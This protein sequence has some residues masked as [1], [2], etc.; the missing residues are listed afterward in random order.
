MKRVCSYYVFCFQLNEK[1]QSTWY[2]WNRGCSAICVYKGE[3]EKESS[4]CIKEEMR[5]NLIFPCVKWNRGIS[6]I[7]SRRRGILVSLSKGQWNISTHILHPVLLFLYFYIVISK[8]WL[9]YWY[10]FQCTASFSWNPFLNT[11]NI[12]VNFLI[13][14]YIPTSVLCK[15]F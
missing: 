14:S 12:Y 2:Y 8:W 5:K 4:R 10:C 13:S 11:T 15:S 6:F 9:N 3:N 7:L 1:L